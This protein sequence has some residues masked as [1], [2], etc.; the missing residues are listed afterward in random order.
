M[1]HVP[2]PLRKS[3]SGPKA[4][5]GLLDDHIYVNQVHFPDITYFNTGGPDES[6]TTKEVLVYIWPFPVVVVPEPIQY[7]TTNGYSVVGNPSRPIDDN[8]L[9]QWEANGGCH[10]HLRIV[11]YNATPADFAPGTT[12]ADPITAALPDSTPP[13]DANGIIVALG[14]AYLQTLDPD[15]VFTLDGLFFDLIFSR[16]TEPTLHSSVATGGPPP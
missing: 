4:L 12:P 6:Q 5:I 11:R 15:A 2:G 14:M 13:A 8:P 3:P 10:S 7:P 16:E 1:V 9:P